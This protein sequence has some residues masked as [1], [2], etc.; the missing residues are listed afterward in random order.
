M[1]YEII[2]DRACATELLEKAYSIS[3]EGGMSTRL[4]LQELLTILKEFNLDCDFAYNAGLFH[5]IGRLQSVTPSVRKSIY[6]N[7]FQ[8]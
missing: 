1:A 8:I 3:L 7:S 4:T 6:I 2:S 5:H